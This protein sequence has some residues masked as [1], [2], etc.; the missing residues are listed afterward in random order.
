MDRLS[1]MGTTAQKLQNIIDSKA[2]ISAAIQT[3][4]GTVPA[5]LTGYAQAILDLPSGGGSYEMPDWLKEKMRQDEIDKKYYG[6]NTDTPELTKIK[7]YGDEMGGWGDADGTL[8]SNQIVNTPWYHVKMSNLGGGQFNAMS[9]MPGSM[10]GFN[11]NNQVSSNVETL[12]WMEDDQLSNSA[13]IIRSGTTSTATAST[14]YCQRIPNVRYINT[15]SMGSNTS[16][17]TAYPPFRNLSKLETLVF[18]KGFPGYSGFTGTNEKRK[19]T[20]CFTQ[21]W[22]TPGCTSLKEVI[23]SPR[24]YLGVSSEQTQNNSSPDWSETQLSSFYIPAERQ[25]YEGMPNNYICPWFFRNA[26]HLKHVHVPGSINEIQYAAFSNVGTSLDGWDSSLP[27]A[28][29]VELGDKAY[30]EDGTTVL[31]DG[32]TKIASRAFQDCSLLYYL[33]LPSSVTSLSGG[34]NSTAYGRQFYNCGGAIIKDGVEVVPAHFTLDCRK[35]HNPPSFA[36]GAMENTQCLPSYGKILVKDA[37]YDNWISIMT[38]NGWT[39][40]AAKVVKESDYTQ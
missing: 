17:N 37:D 13:N 26:T 24:T 31:W 11:D 38:T 9:A 36:L 21:Q 39:A 15:G 10:Y 14:N 27:P 16:Y 7:F 5:Q 8:L 2:A 12:I 18:G 33:E 20:G 19:Y 32:V 22:R 23:T 40:N 1:N 30:A 28:L 4:G 25:S 34:V 35:L 6:D 29:S 3:K